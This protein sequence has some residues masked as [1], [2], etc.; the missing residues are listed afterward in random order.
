MT[1][2]PPDG[3]VA[4][5]MP[6]AGPGWAPA[7]PIT[8]STSRRRGLVT[9]FI[10]ERGYM[11]ALAGGDIR[12]MPYATFGTA[13]LAETAVRGLDGRRATLL[14]NHG[15]I[16][17]GDSLRAAHA[18]AFEVENLATQY[19]AL[20]AAGL[21]PVLLDDAELRRV[22]AKFADYGRLART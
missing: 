18:V 16:A 4:T 2:R 11:I 13:E 6:R 8:A 21:E 10:T 20:L 7:P 14:A 9:G 3:G 1:G 12:C 17:I 5:A 19:L 15:V 22:T